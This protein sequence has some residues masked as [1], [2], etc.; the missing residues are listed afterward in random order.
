MIWPPIAPRR[1]C[2]TTH[3]TCAALSC[4]LP[5]ELRS[6][7]GDP[8][9]VQYDYALVVLAEAIGRRVGWMQVGGGYSNGEGPAEG[10]T[11]PAATGGAVKEGQGTPPTPDHG[12][13]SGRALKGLD[14][15]GGKHPASA[16]RRRGLQQQVQAQALVTVAGYPDDKENGTLWAETCTLDLGAG[17]GNGGGSQGLVAGGA[18]AGV[19]PPPLRTHNCHTRG[20][21]S[22]SPLWVQVRAG[23]GVW[24]S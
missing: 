8:S 21:N 20:G 17:A 11:V 12:G 2:I 18:Q 14:A 13:T 7:A 19:G 22:G 24:V 23:D 5:P 4:L 16:L 3:G 6:G 10:S 9:A 15:Y 1:R